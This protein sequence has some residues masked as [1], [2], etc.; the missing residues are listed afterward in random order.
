MGVTVERIGTKAQRVPEAANNRGG[1][2]ISISFMNTPNL[3]RREG[4]KGISEAAILNGA[5]CVNYKFQ[6]LRDHL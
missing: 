1:F 5:F 4:H 2:R 6:N 3:T